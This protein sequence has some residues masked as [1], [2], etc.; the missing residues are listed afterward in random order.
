MKA[1]GTLAMFLTVVGA[2][3]WGLVGIGGFAETNLNLVNLIF[4]S[5]PTVE[6]VVY[7][8]VGLSGLLVGWAHATKKCEMK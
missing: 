8:L 4:G 3:N 7:I 6:L 1:L 5:M 2:L